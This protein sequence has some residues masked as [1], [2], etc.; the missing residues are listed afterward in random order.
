MGGSLLIQAH[1][2]MTEVSEQQRHQQGKEHPLTLHC[3]GVLA[4]I[5]SKMGYGEEAEEMMSRNLSVAIRNHG[6]NHLGVISASAHYAEILMGLKKLDEAEVI[7]RRISQ[8][9]WY[10]QVARDDGEHVDRIFSLRVL[11]ECLKQQGRYDEALVE[12]VE[13]ERALRRTSNDEGMKHPIYQEFKD[14]H[15]ELEALRDNEI[16]RR[17]S[18][19][20]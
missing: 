9:K 12:C 4:G 15:R 11:T 7:L 19:S 5:K 10:T 8:H 1:E 6:E 16:V 13:M 3:V 20:S 14:K 2:I 17:A 18:L